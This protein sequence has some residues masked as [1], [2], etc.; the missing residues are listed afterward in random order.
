MSRTEFYGR[1]LSAVQWLKRYRARTGKV[2]GNTALALSVDRQ[3]LTNNHF[4]M[5]GILIAMI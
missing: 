5:R 1:P 4:E 2:S 3:H